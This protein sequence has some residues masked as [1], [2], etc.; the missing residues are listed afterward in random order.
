MG[1]LYAGV[2]T[3]VAVTLVFPCVAGAQSETIV[4]GEIGARIDSALTVAARGGFNG[5]VRIE[6]RGKLVLAK[7]YGLANRE[8]KIPFTPATVVQIGSNTK[9]FTLVALMRLEGRGKLS[10][11]DSLGK[12]FPHAPA[13]KRG[14]TLQQ[15]IDHRGGF[16]IGFGGDFDAV[17]REQFLERALASPLRALPGTQEIYSNAGYAILAAVIEQITGKSYDQ[18]VRDDLLM[19]LG[20]RETGYLLPHFAE[21]RLAHGYE[22]GQDRGTILS[23]GHAADGPYWNLRGNGGMLSTV[24]DMHR[25]YKVLFDTDSLL[26]AQVRNGRFDPTGDVGLAGSDLISFFLYERLPRQGVEMIIATNSAESKAPEVR[27][28]I[29]QVLGLPLNVGP[30]GNQNG[31]PAAPPP[32]AKPPSAAVAAVI[33]AFVEAVNSGDPAV[34]RTFIVEHFSTDGSLDQ[35]IQRFGGMRERLGTLSL[36]NMWLD[37]PDSVSAALTTSGQGPAT[38]VF[39]LEHDAPFRIRSL[40][41]LVGG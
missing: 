26:P 40:K 37:G 22:S 4:A 36:R 20:L 38:F 30:G 13:D 32:G 19:P 14:I 31:N 24:S 11:R 28:A 33:N 9:D 3:A 25:F 34:I 1:L 16:P 29:A 41:V 7:G 6:Q 12:F 18:Y 23:H 10:F 35:R 5:V 2:A 8:R 15:I 17:S 21:N 39:D 27:R